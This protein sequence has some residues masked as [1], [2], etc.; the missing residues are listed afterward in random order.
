MLIDRALQKAV[1]S[2]TVLYSPINSF[3]IIQPMCKSAIKICPFPSAVDSI[4]PNSLPVVLMCFP[5][6]V[7][8]RATNVSF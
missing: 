8:A 1:I 2:K 6:C 3:I 5:D 4:E 7:Y